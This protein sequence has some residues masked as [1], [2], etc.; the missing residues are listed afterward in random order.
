MSVLV[1]KDD[2]MPSEQT[3]HGMA[4]TMLASD[5]MWGATVYRDKKAIGSIA[6][7]FL[8]QKT[9]AV[10]RVEISQR[11]GK[12]ALFVR[13][14]DLLFDVDPLRIYL[15][16]GPIEASNVPKQSFLQRFYRI[17]GFWGMG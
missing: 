3:N 7:L 12:P 9:G 8:N 2:N 13:W 15:M 11:L 17:P 6:R 10:E 1:L 5:I 4:V 14:N 16:A